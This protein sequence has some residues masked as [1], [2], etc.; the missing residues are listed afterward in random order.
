MKFTDFIPPILQ[1]KAKFTD[2]PSTNNNPFL[3]TWVNNKSAIWMP[4]DYQSYI[5][6]AYRA[7]VLVYSIISRI[8]NKAAGIT[9]KLRVKNKNGINE[10]ITN[11]EILDRVKKPN[12]E[13]T[14]SELII[15]Y[16]LY[17]LITGNDYTWGLKP[18]I[19]ANKDIFI[20][21]YTLPAQFTL[22]TGYVFTKGAGGYKLTFAPNKIIEPENVMHIKY[23]DPSFDIVNGSAYGLSPIRASVKTITQSNSGYDALTKIYQNLGQT[24]IVTGKNGAMSPDQA[25]MLTDLIKSNRNDIFVTN[26]EIDFKKI[27]LTPEDLAIIDANEMTRT[28][29]CNIFKVPT[30]LFGD[31]SASTY[32]NIRE[33]KASMVEDAVMPEYDIWFEKFNEWY[34]EPFRKRDNKNYELYYDQ[35]QFNELK[36]ALVQ[37]AIALKDIW[38]M[39]GNEKRQAMDLVDS[40]SEYMSEFLIP[41]SLKRLEDVEFDTQKINNELAANRE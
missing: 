18:D 27:G 9:P 12:K 38:W 15:Q 36:A 32:N 37:Q 29:L 10:E 21:L 40:D 28:D 13:T 4:D 30:V 14:W 20:E 31:N 23:Y 22:I 26:A 39:S 7:N 16:F 25:G 17:K 41:S 6:K 11:H 1:R 2:I 33:A 5:D 8:A 19:G 35:Y 34:I 24:G 3:T